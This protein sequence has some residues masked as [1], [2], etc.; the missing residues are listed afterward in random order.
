MRSDASLLLAAVVCLAA[1]G[2]AWAKP[3]V[4]PANPRSDRSPPP[5]LA[6]STGP[7]ATAGS[8]D[9]RY[10][11]VGIARVSGDLQGDA[12]AAA[13]RTLPVGSIAEVTRLDTGRIVL[14][15]IV[16][17]GPDDPRSEIDLT[18]G[19]ARMLGL[20]DGASPVRVRAVTASAQDAA[21]LARGEPASPRMDAPPALL[22]ALRRQLPA[23]APQR[24]PRPSRQVAAV[25]RPARPT[26]PDGRSALDTRPTASR[27]V[28]QV[29]AFATKDRAV[30]VAR[31]LAGSV[32]P[33][34]A[35]WRVRLGP[36]S[37]RGAAQR[38]RDAAARRGY[39][40]AQIVPAS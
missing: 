38:G 9:E 29:A 12:I 4:A 36:Y 19:A 10:D 16:T 8:G 37:D 11:R 35:L 26:A 27:Y 22:V 39:A 1:P 40:D 30:A 5:E 33:A 24:S 21:A 34:G 14:V 15:R 18:P 7:S 32:Q 13:H 17:H 25:S 23:S 20:A 28:V 6:A 3:A 2:S 31:T